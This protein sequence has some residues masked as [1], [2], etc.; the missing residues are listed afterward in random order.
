MWERGGLHPTLYPASRPT[1]WRPRAGPR[2]HQPLWWRL[3]QQ[4]ACLGPKG[5]LWSAAAVQPGAA[6]LDVGAVVGLLCVRSSATAGRGSD[7]C[8]PHML[9]PQRASGAGLPPCPLLS[10]QVRSPYPMGSS[11]PRTPGQTRARGRDT[12]HTVSTD[13]AAMCLQRARRGPENT[14]CFSTSLS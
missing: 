1:A 2:P 8:S 11:R 12:G 14:P 9:R 6:A 10:R 5:A 4:Q 3:R 13:R 7:G